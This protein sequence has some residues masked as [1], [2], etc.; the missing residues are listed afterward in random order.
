MATDT[1]E[2]EATE[3]QPPENP[4]ADAEEATDAPKDAAAESPPP[5]EEPEDDE[6]AD[7]HFDPVAPC[8]DDDAVPCVV[9]TQV[10]WLGLMRRAPTQLVLPRKMFE[11]HER[12]GA[13]R[14]A[15]LA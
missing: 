15:R 9:L 7:W 3:A 13:V 4:A 2:P 10:L 1:V 14:E 8:D 5:E 11:R 6:P 12:L